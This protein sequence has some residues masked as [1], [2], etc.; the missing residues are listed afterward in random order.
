VVRLSAERQH[1]DRGATCRFAEGGYIIRSQV[2]TSLLG[3][4]NMGSGLRQLA[5]GEPVRVLPASSVNVPYPTRSEQLQY[6]RI[7][8]S[9]RDKHESIP[10]F[11]IR[12]EY[13]T[14]PRARQ[15][16]PATKACDMETCRGWWKPA[17]AGAGNTERHAI[18]QDRVL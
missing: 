10:I 13:L 4:V 17:V 16:E 14:K 6:D 11:T 9:F 2:N 1:L 15:V 5:C 8:S 18:E 7:S 12:K 3:V